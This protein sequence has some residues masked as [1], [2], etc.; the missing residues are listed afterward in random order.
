MR[1]LKAPENEDFEGLKLFHDSAKFFVGL[2]FALE[3]AL[4]ALIASNTYHEFAVYTPLV[5]L[6]ILSVAVGVFAGGTVVA[7]P[8]L[9]ERVKFPE[10]E[11]WSGIRVDERK[12]MVE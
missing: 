11:D 10:S 3:G 1:R 2:F 12:Q 7:Y 5:D 4:G 9:S 6:G 8:L